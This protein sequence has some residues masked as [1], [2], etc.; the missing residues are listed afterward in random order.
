MFK[1]NLTLALRNL[2]KYKG[3]SFINLFGLSI[4]LSCCLLIGIYIANELSFDRYHA[5]AERIWRVSREF[6]NKDGTMQ[7]HLGHLA[8]PFGPLLKNEFSV[9]EDAT[10]ML[11][12]NASLRRGDQLFLEEEF[13]F[14]EPGTF[15]M[16]DIPLVQGSIASIDEP[17]TVLLSERSAKKIFGD[18]DPVNQVLRANDLLDLKVTGVYKDF[19]YNSHFHPDFLASFATMRDTN[20]YG[21]Q[22][23]ETNWGNNSFSTFLLLPEGYEGSK[24]EAQFPAFLDKVMASVYSGNGMLKPSDMTSLHLMPL[25]DIHLKSHLDSEL[26]ENGDLR[27]VYIF[28]AIAL[29]VLLIACVNYMNLS[30]A[31]SATRAKE[32]GIRKVVGAYRREIIGQFLSE[33]VLLSLSAVILACLLTFLMLPAV[34][35]LLGQE[36]TVSYGQAGTFALAAGAL[37]L[38]TGLLAGAYPA[39][40][41][42]GLRPLKIIRGGTGNEQSGSGINLRKI[43]VVSQ[44]SISLILIIATLVVFTQLKFMQ[45][46]SLGLNK[47]QVVT[48]NFYNPLASKYDAFYN[49]LLSSSVIKNATRS[50][51]LPSGRLLDSFGSA[52]LQMNGDTLEPTQVDLKMVTIDHRFFPLYDIGMAAGR[53][54]QSDQGMD[55]RSSFILNEAAIRNLR[56]PSSEEAIGKRIN[57]GNRDAQIVGVVKDFN[58]ES[59]HQDILPMIFFVPSDSTF[60]NFISIKIDGAR[61]T[62]ALAH[63]Q[64]TWQK[65]LPEFP[66]DYSFLDEQYGQLYEAEQRQGRVFIAFAL[67]AIVVACLGLFGLASFTVERRHKEI[68]IR[69]VL[70]ASVT[71]ITGLL[72]KDF[73][74]LVLVAIVIASPVAYWVMGKWLAD[75]AYRINISWWMFVLAGILA[76]A[77]AFL[78]VSFQSVKAALMN[79]VRSLRSE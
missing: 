10:R 39:F 30:T 53:N 45:S 36:L 9:I 76:L 48:L 51:R 41:L 64:A 65:F 29:F 73:L 78:T 56:I 20:I 8:P 44:F 67:I 7:L 70:G 6:R 59:L 40:F 43:L 61:T 69:K 32:I 22:Q 15:R 17:Y 42:S 18:Q 25:T 12:T 58:F 38:A 13:F 72:A 34:N 75:F 23:L 62:E 60:F 71:G 35:K 24:L 26:E 16:F 46:K 14:A 57:Y 49:E 50:S 66:Y 4:G 52:Q 33:A 11:Q 31:R 68:G 79:P 2:L 63:I 19:P 3:F 77:I 74:K 21:Q 37:A 55:R 5:K 54:Y 28:A 1:I 27:R 47:D